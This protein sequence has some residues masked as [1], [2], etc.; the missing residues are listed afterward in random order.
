LSRA[1]FD[2]GGMVEFFQIMS[3]LSGDAGSI[4]YLR[5]HPLSN[6]RVAEAIDRT[7]KLSAGSDQVDDYLLFKDYLFY[8]SHDHLPDQGSDFLLALALVKKARYQEADRRLEEFYNLYPENIWY[9]IAYA[10]NLEYLERVDEAEL[11]YRRLLDIF[12]GDYVLSMRLLRLLKQEDRYQAALTLARQLEI[13]Y[14]EQQQV[15][16]EL[17]EIYQALDRPA[18]KLMAE[19]EFHRINGNTKQAIRLYDQVLKSANVDMATLSKAREKRLALI[20]Q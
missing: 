6:N 9:S 15:Y 10:E 19:A 2:P 14:P 5:T 8:T 12:P 20:G 18:M 13:G 17:S 11:V 3:D 7:S 4:E 1:H 16:F